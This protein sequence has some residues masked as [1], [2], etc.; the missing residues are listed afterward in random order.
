MKL[1]RPTQVNIHEW[2]DYY[3]D[4][5][6]HEQA[7]KHHIEEISYAMKNKIATQENQYKHTQ[8]IGNTKY[9]QSNQI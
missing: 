9:Q 7:H 8:L 4:S 5:T 1:Y 6:T 2:I 3:E